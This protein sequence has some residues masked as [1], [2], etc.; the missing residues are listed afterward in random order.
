MSLARFM[1]MNRFSKFEET[2]PSIDGLTFNAWPL[3]RVVL[4]ELEWPEWEKIAGDVRTQLTDETIDRA[5]AG[6]PD[7]YF[8]I[9]GSEM[10]GRLLA[11]RDQMVEITRRFYLHLAGDADVICSEVDDVI[12]LV[13][14]PGGDLDLSVSVGS[15]PRFRRLFRKGETREVRIYLGDGNDR[16]EIEGEGAGGPRVYVIGRGP[17]QSTVIQVGSAT[18]IWSRIDPLLPSRTKRI[19][20][21]S[22]IRIRVP[23][24]CIHAIGARLRRRWCL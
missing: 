19:C 12:R 11:R 5:L 24:G 7:E 20:M 10:K 6:M 8:Q 23:P 14:S 18:S 16:V 4:P 22:R 1:G 21:G 9:V 2:Y 3:D 15:T 17:L 13:R